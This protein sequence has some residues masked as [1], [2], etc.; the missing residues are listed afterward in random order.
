MKTSKPRFIMVVGLQK[1]GTSVLSRLL[2][3]TNLVGKPFKGE[4]DDF[5]GNLPKFSPTEFPC[6]ELYQRYNGDRGHELGEEDV[7]DRV[8]EVMHERFSNLKGKHL[9][10]VNKSPYN[11]VR[12]PWIRKVFPD[13]LIVA[14]VRR[15]VANVFSL[16]K[17][18][19]PHQ[20]SG[21]PPEE[22]W[23]G[24][25]PVGWRDMVSDDKVAQCAQQWRAVNE[26]L[27]EHRDYVDLVV[28]YHSFC[29]NP[30]LWL[31]KIISMVSGEPVTLPPDTGIEPLQCFDDEYKTGA[32]L[33]S[34]N[35]Y[36]KELKSFQVPEDD[37][38]ELNPL[39]DEQVQMIEEM[40]SDTMAKLEQA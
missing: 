1:S 11:T 32:R 27:Y 35:R 9:I 26:K 31:E 6:G 24:T 3:Q 33:R 20:Q 17:K 38:V 5:W 22:G 2:L 25:K 19:V 39:A 34:K 36:W 21:L 40:C 14:S 23:W 4:G 12:L 18:Y 8:I 29:E 28:G 16:S 30:V 10:V 15:P 37:K 7:D 13:S